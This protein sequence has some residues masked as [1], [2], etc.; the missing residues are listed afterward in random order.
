MQGEDVAARGRVLLF[1]VDKT[2]DNSRT[3]VSSVSFGFIFIFTCLHLSSQNKL[4]VFMY[5]F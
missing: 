2:N 1:N 4:F 3:P 5:M